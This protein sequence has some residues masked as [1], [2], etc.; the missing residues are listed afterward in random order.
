MTKTILKSFSLTALVVLLQSFDLPTGWGKAGSKPDSYE[1][2]IDKGAGQ[3]GTNAATVKSIDKTIEGFGTL[4]QQCVVGK[5]LGKRVRMTG[6]IKSENV[7]NW[8]GFWFRVD[9]A[10]TQKSI[11]LDNMANRPIKGT[12]DWTK[13]ELVLDVPKNASLISYGALLNGTG[14]IW[15]DNITIEIVD[16]TIPTTAEGKNN[17]TG[18]QDEPTNLDFEK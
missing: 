10:G 2:G 7:S 14:Q 15:F 12:T 4:M 8:A 18:T 5:Y 1:M 3:N 13:Y 17:K 11:A 6:F 9:Q 16:N